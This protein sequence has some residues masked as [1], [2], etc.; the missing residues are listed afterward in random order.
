MIAG[1]KSF[2]PDIDKNYGYDG[3]IYLGALLEY[4]YGQ[5]KDIEARQKQLKMHKIA[6]AKLFGLGKSS[7]SKP[8][9]I[10]EHA[11]VLYDLLKAEL[12]E[13]DEDD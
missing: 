5:K 10:L 4:R 11:R 3:V 7:K 2:G 13:T 9:P 1:L 6:L 8:G 12:N